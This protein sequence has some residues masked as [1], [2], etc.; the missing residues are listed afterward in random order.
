MKLQIE[1]GRLRLRLT[2]AQLDTLLR[3]SRVDASL[4]CPSGERAHRVLVL[5]TGL[6]AATCD[7]D[8]MDLRIGL[9]RAGFEAFA[10]E[11]P[12][13]DGFVFTAGAVEITVEVDVRDSRRRQLTGNPAVG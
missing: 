4:P 6:T 13:R 1:E 2:E 7:G 11:R 8:L 12:R 9:P 3:D 10:S 5:D